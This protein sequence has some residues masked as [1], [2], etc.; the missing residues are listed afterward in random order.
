MVQPYHR[1]AVLCAL[2]A[3]A[4]AFTGC[5]DEAGTSVHTAPSGSNNATNNATNNGATT[6]NAVTSRQRPVAEAGPDLDA[7]VGEPVTLDGSGSHDEDGQLVTWL[8]TFEDGTAKQ[9]ESVTATF[10]AAGV[11][12]VTLEVIDNDG[13]RDTDELLVRI[14]RPNAPPV[15]AI[16]APA[17]AVEDEPYTVSGAGSTDD[18]GVVGWSWLFGDETDGAGPTEGDAEADGQA[19]HTYTEFGEYTISVTATDASGAT[20]T[21]SEPI[22]VLARPEAVMEGPRSGLVGM[23]LSFSAEASTDRDGQLVRYFWDFDDNL[24]GDGPTVTHTWTQPGGFEVSVTVTDNDGLE[25]AAGFKVTITP[26]PN[27]PPVADCGAAS[28]MH[29]LNADVTL[30][31]SASSD[32]DGQIVSWMWDAGD[33]TG[34]VLGEVVAHRYAELGTWT[35]TLTV[36]DDLGATDTASCDIE[37]VLP[38]NQGPMALCA[39]SPNPVRTDA[40]ATLDGSASADADGRIVAWS[41]DP[42]DGTA[43]LTGAVA[44]HRYDA[45]GTWT[46][47]LTVTDDRG[48]THSTTC[49]VEAVLPPNIAPTADCSVLPNPATVGQ[50][51]TFDAAGSTDTDGQLVAWRWNAGDG[52]ADQDGETITHTW[53]RAGSFDVTLTVTDD[54]GGEDTARCPVQVMLPPNVLPVAACSASPLEADL[55]EVV[56]FDGRGSMDPDGTLVGWSWDFMDGSPAGVGAQVTHMWQAIGDYPVRLTVTDDRGGTDHADCGVKIVDNN[57]PPVAD[58]SAT[59]D[60][61]EVGFPFILDG[62][63]SSDPDG[64]L[65][66]FRWD[67]GD[68]SNAVFGQRVGHI[69]TGAGS[70][71]LT[72][73][74]TDDRGASASTTCPITARS[75]TPPVAVLTTQNTTYGVGEAIVFNGRDSYD[76][77]EPDDSIVRYDWDFDDG[78]T[79][80]GATAQQA[81]HAFTTAGVYLVA[82]TVTDSHGATDLA[83]VTVEV[84]GSTSTIEGTYS[85]N[86]AVQYSCGY[87]LFGFYIELLNINVTRLDFSIQGSSLE[88][89]G[90]P[91]FADGNSDTVVMTEV[92]VPTGA[93]PTFDV[94][95]Q[96]TGGC[97]ETYTA[98]GTF[99]DADTWSGNVTI[100]FTG[101]Q[102]GDTTCMGSNVFPVVGTRQ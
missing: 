7:T 74:V 40:E 99:T 85:L 44:R 102:C 48:D 47:T 9:G 32:P 45:V 73:T 75:N 33:G 81:S 14:D 20:G 57:Q 35:A 64:D 88:V 89:R 94:R 98:T 23:T 58:C 30:D 83:E 15:A 51:A 24:F 50:P 12:Q 59:A 97:T 52:S 66:T 80:S 55:G 82:L 41:W 17:F 101:S 91:Q 71:V 90:G 69:Y 63:L 1:R 46:A 5:G 61:V 62:S 43:L 65:V 26:V 21:A 76:P 18:L 93:L 10:A 38:P 22:R 96:V 67:P 70:F 39:I 8:W 100:A 25:A 11:Q 56:S 4:L 60:I 3:S 92:P 79:D 16:D 72:L 68:G 37:V 95:H 6:N 27:D 87:D 36:T 86:A 49:E 54:R 31:G 13:L 42:G 2:F 78:T 19:V 29:P 77:D 53:D 84:I 28:R 34:T